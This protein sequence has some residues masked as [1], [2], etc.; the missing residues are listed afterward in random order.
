MIVMLAILTV[1]FFVSV[2]LMCIFRYKMNPRFW[3]IAF[4]VADLAF[5]FCWNLA[6]LERGW[7]DEGWM[8]LENIS[9][10]CCTLVPL[11]LI[12]ND[13]VKQATYCFISFLSVGLFVAM[14]IS[15][16]HAYLFSYN[17][18][19]NFLY[20]SEAACHLVCSLF[21][22]YLV[23]SGQVK[24]DFASW[25]RSIIFAASVIGFGVFLNFVFHKT[26]FGMDPYG[27][28]AI[29]MIDI[30]D[31]HAATLAAYCA[32]VVV[33]LTVGMQAMRFLDV[34]SEMLV[35]ETPSGEVPLYHNVT[36]LPSD[37]G[38]DASSSAEDEKIPLGCA[39]D[40][41]EENDDFPDAP[42]DETNLTKSI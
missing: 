28:S 38:E 25:L 20:T 33:V 22:I 41:T 5:Y 40:S 36:V 23:L 18:E 6:A 30:F 11:T 3:N 35:G 15:P 19:A 42:A 34:S 17:I 37:A 13:K 1:L 8:T 16:E 27:N 4:I 12:M 29:Y 31:S 7:L 9:P 32:G 2:S 21:G 39:P 10:L 24:P 26:H 14:L